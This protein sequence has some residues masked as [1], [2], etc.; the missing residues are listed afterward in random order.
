MPVAELFLQ[1]IL[2]VHI[3]TGVNPVTTASELVVG[4]LFGPFIFFHQVGNDV[5][6]NRV[7]IVRG[8]T[9]GQCLDIIRLGNLLVNRNP[10]CQKFVMLL[11][12]DI[13]LGILITIEHEVNHL[14]VFLF[15]LSNRND[16]G[17][18]I[19][20]QF[21][22]SDISFLIHHRKNVVIAPD[23]V[24]DRIEIGPQPVGR[25][26]RRCQRCRLRNCQFPDVTSEIIL[27]SRFN[28]V[29]PAAQ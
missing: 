17:R 12:C 10:V 14:N 18:E 8:N 2:H 28:S 20:F 15:R 23:I 5:P 24:V 3:H 26:G 4:I 27:G 11:L 19:F 29:V 25:T 1:I 6:D 22:L 7:N 13:R 21:C 9:A 16:R